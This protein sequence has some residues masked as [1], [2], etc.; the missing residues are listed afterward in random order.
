MPST[1]TLEMA[2]H[3]LGSLPSSSSLKFPW[4]DS[5]IK[6]TKRKALLGGRGGWG[7]GCF[8]ASSVDSRMYS[9]HKGHGHSNGMAAQPIKGTDRR[10][11]QDTK[12]PRG[13][14]AGGP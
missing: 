13:G 7:W 10:H 12:D 3:C 11:T 1:H 8:A 2:E 6:N 4:T 9:T 5:S 14:Q